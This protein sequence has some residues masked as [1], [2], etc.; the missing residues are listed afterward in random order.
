VKKLLEKTFVHVSDTTEASLVDAVGYKRGDRIS[1]Y[2]N[3]E[4]MQL[5]S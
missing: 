2:I 3:S 4:V 1:S 5:L